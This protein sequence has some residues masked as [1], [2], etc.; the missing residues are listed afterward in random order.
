MSSDALIHLLRNCDL[1]VDMV[2]RQTTRLG[3]LPKKL[4]QSVI[5]QAEPQGAHL[6]FEAL[7]MHVRESLNME[8]FLLTS[9]AITIFGCGAYTR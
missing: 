4:N 7:G 1:D 8:I 2:P 5:E 3:K 9:V 6:L